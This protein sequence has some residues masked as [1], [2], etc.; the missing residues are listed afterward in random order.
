MPKCACL[1]FCKS[2]R[3]NRFWWVKLGKFYKG[4]WLTLNR[5]N[6]FILTEKWKYK[7][8]THNQMQYIFIEYFLCI[9]NKSIHSVSVLPL[10]HWM[11]TLSSYVRFLLTFFNYH[12]FIIK[13]VLYYTLP[14]ATW[15]KV[16]VFFLLYLG[17]N[18]RK[19]WA[20]LIPVPKFSKI[21]NSYFVWAK[22]G[23]IMYYT[24]F[25]R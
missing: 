23:D 24:F 19:N 11:T 22:Y 10:I 5:D 18:M 2:L 8:K 7:R 1:E 4:G 20:P 17:K 14:E 21:L 12:R 15:L 3:R 9:A 25:H 6:F 16:G 13:A